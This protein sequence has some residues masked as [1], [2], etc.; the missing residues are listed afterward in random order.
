MGPFHV[1]T[2]TFAALPVVVPGIASPGVAALSR[3]Y[4]T[5]TASQPLAGVRTGTKDIF[6]IAGLQTSNGNRAFEDLYPPQNTT[7]LPVQR[8]IDAGAIVGKMKTSQ[9]ANGEIATVDWVDY[10]EPFSPCRDGY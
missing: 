6:D 2:S 10:H 4:Y 8:L 7:T 5:K 9:F 1:N 3:L